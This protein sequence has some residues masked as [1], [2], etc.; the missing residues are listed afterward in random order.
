MIQF[1]NAEQA[2]KA[3]RSPKA[4][5]QNRFIKVY[6]GSIGHN[7]FQKINV[8]KTSSSDI[9]GD[10][11]PKT[12]PVWHAKFEASSMKYHSPS[13]F[14][15]KSITPPAKNINV[16]EREKLLKLVNIEF[17]QLEEAMAHQKCLMEKLKCTTTPE[18]KTSILEMLKLAMYNIKELQRTLQQKQALIKL[19][20]RT[21]K[22]N[23][24]RGHRESTSP[25]SYTS[26]S[27]GSNI[28]KDFTIQ[29][30][31]DEDYVSNQS[32]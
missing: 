32:S 27:P 18:E 16:L 25:L 14:T 19:A 24:G 4:V 6:Y 26:N 13:T 7:A 15:T 3:F 11:K 31:D 20:Q 30:S 12:A 1:A 29:Y 5:L 22:V 17:R 21:V 9:S 28:G 2:L 10:V 23:C 8:K